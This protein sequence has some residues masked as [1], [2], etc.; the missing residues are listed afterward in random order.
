MVLKG[1]GGKKRGGVRE[2]VWE[3]MHCPNQSGMRGEETEGLRHSKPVPS[4]HI[5]KIKKLVLTEEGHH[6]NDTV[7]Q[8]IPQ[9]RNHSQAQRF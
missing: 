1:V 5:F 7:T 2:A 6:V 3:G 9:K 8:T 4:K